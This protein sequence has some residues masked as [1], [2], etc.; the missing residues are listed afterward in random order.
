MTTISYQFRESNENERKL[1]EEFENYLSTKVD[2]NPAQAISLC[3][4]III[5]ISRTGNDEQRKDIAEYLR[6]VSEFI[7]PK[8]DTEM[9]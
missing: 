5:R 4:N 1:I 8:S 9:N 3:M 2:K 7:E 6:Y